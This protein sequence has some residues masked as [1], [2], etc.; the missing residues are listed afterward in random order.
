MVMALT[1]VTSFGCFLISNQLSKRALQETVEDDLMNL[2]KSI[3]T[4]ITEETN[5][6]FTTLNTLATLSFMKDEKNDLWAK[7]VQLD[8]VKFSGKVKNLIGVNIADEKGDCY[9]VEGGLVN[10][11]ERDYCKAALSGKQY[12]QNPM[13]NKVTNVL[14]MFYAVPVFNSDNKVIGTIFACT[15]GESLCDVCRSY[16]IGKTGYPVIIDRT[17][18][19]TVGDVNTD[20]VLNFTNLSEETKDIPAYAELNEMHQRIRRGETGSGYYT[21]NGQRKVCAFIPIEGTNWTIFCQAPISE[22]S[23]HITTMRNM[24][25]IVFLVSILLGVAISIVIGRNLMP[26]ASAAGEIDEMSSGNADLSVRLKEL[27]SEN[28]IA[29]VVGGINRFISKLQK[30]IANIK[31]SKDRLTQVDQN[32][33]QA[34]KDTAGAIGE[35]LNNLENVNGQ[36]DNQSNNV[37]ETVSAVNQIAGNIESL[38]KLISNQVSGVSQASTAIEEMV[39]NISAVNASV[40]KMVNSFTSLEENVQSGTAKQ[41]DVGKKI[42][43][44]ETQSQMLQDANKA[45]ASIASQTNLLAMN[46]AIEAAHAGE[47]G[48]GFSVVADEIRKLSETSS[49]QSKTIGDE[50]KKILGSIRQVVEASLTATQTFEEVS[51]NIQQTNQMVYQ[52]KNAMEEQTAGSKQIIDVLYTMNDSTNEVRIASDEMSEGN[53]AV[54]NGVHNLQNSTMV[55]RDQMNQMQANADKISDTGTALSAITDRVTET[56]QKIGVEIDQFKV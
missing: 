34:S 50:L 36:I 40:D 25:L 55:I 51:A 39:A 7:Q 10:F 33:Q 5:S 28:E 53:K 19:I 31:D 30:I 3:A 23:G 29:H 15:N 37:N 16:T 12:I 52:I 49:A 44:I 38:E 2:A 27:N 6:Q 11:A 1:V 20:N 21:Y 56:I 24:M 32:L 17:T 47:A 41:A 9:V 13:I 43:V 45:I 4:S 48:A 22:F 26:L 35:I 54:L 14:S 18:G 46:A 8:G 42:A